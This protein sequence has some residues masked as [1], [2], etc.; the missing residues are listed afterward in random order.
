MYRVDAELLPEVSAFSER[1]RELESQA[2]AAS[3]GQRYLLERKLEGERKTEVQAVS[4]R[5]VSFIVDR[6][7]AHAAGVD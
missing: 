3:P 1:V 6:L 4:Q 2:A 7:G 5:I